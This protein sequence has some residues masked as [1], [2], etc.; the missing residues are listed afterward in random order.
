MVEQGE[1]VQLVVCEQP[2]VEQGRRKHGVGG[3][4]GELDK[5]RERQGHLCDLLLEFLV[6]C[7]GPSCTA[8]AGYYAGVVVVAATGCPR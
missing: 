1:L 3:A 5:W 7:L 8:E 6:A 2:E 4:R